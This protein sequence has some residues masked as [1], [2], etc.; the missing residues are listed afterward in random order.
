MSP[1]CCFIG[2]SQAGRGR[3]RFIVRVKA[4][5]RKTPPRHRRLDSSALMSFSSIN[6]SVQQLMFTHC[7]QHRSKIT[8][9]SA[10]V[11]ASRSFW[12]L[13]MPL[14]LISP[15]ELHQ[16]DYSHV[17]SRDEMMRFGLK[18][19]AEPLSCSQMEKEKRASVRLR[20]MLICCNVSV[21][22]AANVQADTFRWRSRPRKA[23]RV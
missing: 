3:P 22:A 13:L 4:S 14:L 10:E 2:R 6:V 12:N 8:V 20:V 5:P 11:A 21:A 16:W 23:F 19:A 9:H 7:F 18:A 1:T 17:R 15:D